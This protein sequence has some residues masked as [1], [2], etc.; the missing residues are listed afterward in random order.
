MKLQSKLITAVVLPLAIIG[1]G[2]AQANTLPDEQF[3]VGNPPTNERY[4][5]INLA[6]ADFAV[7]SFSSLEAMTGN[8]TT[9]DA[10]IKSTQ[11][12]NTDA[13]GTDVLGNSFSADSK[14]A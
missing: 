10:T 11:V 14:V 6:D 7:D 12:G 9:P 4:T 2:L 8:G 3:V 1:S 13:R 5:G